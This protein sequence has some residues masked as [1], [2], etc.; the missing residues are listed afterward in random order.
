MRKLRLYLNGKVVL[1]EADE[2]SESGKPVHINSILVDNC[3]KK[4]KIVV[5]KES[6]EEVTVN[7]IIDKQTFEIF[8]KMM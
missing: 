4:I 3:S 8:K 7:V 2:T 6:D 1:H 5:L